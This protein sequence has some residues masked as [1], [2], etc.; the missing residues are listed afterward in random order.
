MNFIERL[1]FAKAFFSLVND[2]QATENV[3]KIGK[4]GL[5]YPDS[6]AMQAMLK[7]VYSDPEFK[8]Q[9]EEK[10]FPEF[11]DLEDLAKLPDGTVGKEFYGHMKRNNLAVDF[12]PK[13]DISL[14]MS[15]AIMRLRVTHDLWHV[16]AGYD[17]TPMGELAL[18]AFAFAQARTGIAPVLMSAGFMG[19]NRRHEVDPMEYIPAISHAF[20]RGKRAKSLLSLKYE[21]IWE[22]RLDEIRK[23]LN[24]L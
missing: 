15:Y 18:Q 1:K 10:Y 7:H 14:P 8:K 11:V 24:L 17:T 20:E 13:E 23:E 9:F 19:I 16:L 22:R 5:R 2:P 21:Q 6:P 4:I 3:F 12:F